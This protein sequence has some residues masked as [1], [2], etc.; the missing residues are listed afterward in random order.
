MNRFKN[1]PR[2][3]ANQLENIYVYMYCISENK[4]IYYKDVKINL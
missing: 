3:G 4:K 1:K 2:E